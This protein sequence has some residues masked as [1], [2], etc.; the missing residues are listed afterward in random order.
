MSTI[1][2][3]ERSSIQLPAPL[4]KRLLA[5]ARR[6][7]YRIQ[8]GPGGQTA[9]FIAW[10]LDQHTPHLDGRDPATLLLQF[11]DHIAPE[12]DALRAVAG[13]LD[14][15][16]DLQVDTAEG[17]LCIRLSSTKTQSDKPT[18]VGLGPETHA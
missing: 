5:T 14:L 13:T 7:G 11:T 15:A 4:K 2:D 16:V 10:L 6:A 3:M 9:E 18:R 8:P 12:L 1:K 17:R